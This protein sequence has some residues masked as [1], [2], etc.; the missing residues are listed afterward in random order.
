LHRL[1][2]KT[3]GLIEPLKNALSKYEDRIGTAFVYGSVARGE[4]TSYSDID[5]LIIGDD[6]TYADIYAQRVDASGLV[7][8]S[9]AGVR[10]CGAN[11]QQTAAKLAADGAGGALATWQDQ[12]SGTHTEIYAQHVTGAGALAAGWPADGLALCANTYPQQTP[13]IVSNVT[14]GAIVAWEDRR[15]GGADIYAGRIEG[16]G[17]I[18]TAVEAP[19][20][21]EPLIVNRNAADRLFLRTFF[22]VIPAVYVI[23]AV[24]QYL[25]VRTIPLAL[26]DIPRI[27]SECAM[28]LA[29]ALSVLLFAFFPHGL[30]ELFRSGVLRIRTATHRDWTEEMFMQAIRTVYR[31]EMWMDPRMSSAL[32]DELSHMGGETDTASMRHENGLTERELEI[33]RLVASG[34]KNKEVG[35]S[36]S[37][38]ERTVKTHLTNIFQKL[39]VRDRVGLVMYALKH[40][41]TGAAAS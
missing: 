33:V 40:G 32:V 6:L 2:L 24:L 7:Q 18:V 28:L 38:S 1:I 11:D 8:W 30:R 31:G 21:R 22:I 34:Y 15:S 26:I 5:L 3:A 37:I 23:R 39:G 9:N 12:R 41:L 19:P 16:G 20:P 25:Q 10:L 29:L 4:D 14:G 36:L 17:T 27:A 13:V 35:S